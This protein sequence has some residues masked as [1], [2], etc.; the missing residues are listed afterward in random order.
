M[1]SQAR[2]GEIFKGFFALPARRLRGK[3][4]AYAR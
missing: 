3:H 4:M 2:T 1:C